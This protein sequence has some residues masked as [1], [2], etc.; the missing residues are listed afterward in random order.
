MRWI[1]EFWT[2]FDEVSVMKKKT[3]LSDKHILHLHLLLTDS[4]NLQT[5]KEKI[6]YIDVSSTALA[7][8]H[9]LGIPLL[10]DK[11]SSSVSL[12]SNHD[13]LKTPQT[14]GFIQFLLANL[15]TSSQEALHHEDFKAIRQL[16][17][18]A[19]V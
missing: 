11:F 14:S 5:I 10:F 9:Q 1:L 18:E 17:Y 15:D 8:W 4:N 19:I 13:F 2:W 3:L 6:T 12:F 16:L 7:P